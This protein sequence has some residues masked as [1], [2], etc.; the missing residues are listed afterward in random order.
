MQSWQMFVKNPPMHSVDIIETASL[1][2]FTTTFVVQAKF[3]G[4]MPAAYP[5][6][7]L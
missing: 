3:A 6:R 7:A 4:Q 1:T 2:Q 5:E